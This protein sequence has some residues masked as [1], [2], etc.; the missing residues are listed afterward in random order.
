M[1]NE[2]ERIYTQMV[3][4]NPEITKA[5]TEFG[6]AC[7]QAGEA[8]G[9]AVRAAVNCITAWTR[10]VDL[11]Q[12]VRELQAI[13]EAPPRV[14]HLALHGK[15]RRTRKKNINRALREYQKRRPT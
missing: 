12:C 2:Q 14:R 7:K 9:K 6:E 8:L 10:G 11:E 4:S 3:R 13:K 5:I 15:K 1:T